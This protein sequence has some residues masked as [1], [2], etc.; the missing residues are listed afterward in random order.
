[1]V[2]RFSCP[3]RSWIFVAVGDHNELSI[4]RFA[5]AQQR[6]EERFVDWRCVLRS[7]D[8]IPAHALRFDNLAVQSFRALRVD[9]CAL[10]FIAMNRRDA[11]PA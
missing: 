10:V 5:V 1:M 4:V 3:H 11:F 7:R 8:D 9:T 6:F 2:F